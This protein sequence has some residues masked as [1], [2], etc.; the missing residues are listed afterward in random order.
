M[1]IDVLTA[2]DGSMCGNFYGMCCSKKVMVQDEI[3]E[4]TRMAYGVETELQW[5]WLTTRVMTQVSAMSTEECFR[6]PKSHLVP[7]LN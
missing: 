5:E 3:L 1:G 2:K 4:R 6:E 7:L